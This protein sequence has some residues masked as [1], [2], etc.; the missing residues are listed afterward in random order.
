MQL[1]DRRPFSTALIAVTAMSMLVSVAQ[2]Q[3][4]PQKTK[5]A[6]TLSSVL[7]QLSLYPRDP[8]LQYVAI[9]LAHQEGQGPAIENRVSSILR[10]VRPNTRQARDVNAFGLFS[11]SLAIQESLQLDRLSGQDRGGRQNPGGLQNSTVS[12]STI[13]GPTIKAHPWT[14]ML[15]GREPEVSDLAR[16]V[17]GDQFYVEA[18]SVGKLLELTDVADL[19]GRHITT[20][21]TLQARTQLS[22]PRLVTQL[23]L[24]VN[25]PL[26]P[27]YDKVVGRVA[28]TGSDVFFREGTDITLLF[29]VKEPLAFKTRMQLFL[30]QAET[31]H[32]EA[33]RTQGEYRGVKYEHLSTPDR[34]LHVYSAYPD[35]KLHLRSNSIVGLRN[36]IDAMRGEADGKAIAPL[37]DTDEFKYIRTLMVTG[38]AREDILVYLSDAFIR[39]LVGPE[40][41]LTE[42][43]RMHCYN[44][45]RMVGHASLMFQTQ[46]GRNAE[47]LEELVATGCAPESLIN[48][49]FACPDGGRYVLDRDGLGASCSHHGHA[50]CLKPCCEIPVAKVT[51]EEAAAYRQFLTRYNSYWRN[52]FD[53]I[54]VRIQV[55]PERYRIETIILPL[56]DNSIYTGLAQALGGHPTALVEK[57]IPDRSIFTTSFHID[58]RIIAG[59]LGVDELLVDAEGEPDTAAVDSRAEAGRIGAS[60]NNLGIA[61]H[62]FHDVHSRFPPVHD[63]NVPKE[64]KLSWRVH[65]LPYLGGDAQRLHDQFNLEEAWDSPHNKA[66]IKQMP[67]IYRPRNSKLGQKGMTQIVVPVGKGMICEEVGTSVVIRSIVDGLSNTIMVTECDEENAVIWTKP[68]DWEVN[69]E[70]PF[71]GLNVRREKAFLATM[72]DGRVVFIREAIGETRLRHLLGRNDGKAVNISGD[73][74]VQLA[75]PRRNQPNS[76]ERRVGELELGRFVM[77]G[78]GDQVSFHVYDGDPLVNISLPMVISEVARDLSRGRGL[79]D[80]VLF[81]GALLASLSSPVYASVPVQDKQIVDRFLDRLDDVLAKQVRTPFNGGFFEVKE[82]FYRFPVRKDVNARAFTIQFGPIKARMFWGRVGDALYVTSKAYILEDL[83]NAGEHEVTPQQ[84]EDSTAHALIRLRPSQWKQIVSSFQL[85]WAESHR[86]ACHA[87]LG[88]LSNISRASTSA[89]QGVRRQTID[90][91]AARVYDS[92]FY[93]PDHGD[94]IVDKEGRVVRCSVHGWVMEPEQLSHLGESSAFA[95]LMTDLQEIQMT[96]TFLEDGLHAVV[97]LDRNAN[98]D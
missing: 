74:I 67:D 28:I 82:D 49:G 66:L 20:Q 11:G 52:F 83:I 62:T 33:Q 30:T 79:D 85:G 97:T 23:A 41:K 24:D 64:R 65:I 95:K 39:R 13:E 91:L 10:S 90:E 9:Q 2:A 84:I 6:W 88:A 53:P 40:V 94:Y 70:E 29:E 43:R 56:I 72:A 25:D 46:Y 60:L 21:G 35:E 58:K 15:A 50:E 86:M 26:R 69:L 87:N 47:S 1:T 37:G 89:G 59:Q 78:I 22:V 98:S 54:A 12:M 31:Q 63:R 8:Y 81:I 4:V 48:G 44:H 7:E 32:P 17:P 38:D 36:A 19:W 75:I 93:C 68:A 77:R 96:L 16:L 57:R 42:L 71:D 45:M 14:E 34:H 5:Q 76:L 27:I 3:D 18:R 61:F 80:D 92:H 73:D 55:A 51:G